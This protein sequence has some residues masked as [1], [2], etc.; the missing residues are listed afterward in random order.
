MKDAFLLII[1]G[2]HT[3]LF[4]ACAEIIIVSCSKKAKIITV[5]DLHQN[6]SWHIFFDIC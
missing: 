5:F 4:S 1:K 6:Y 3:F 2:R